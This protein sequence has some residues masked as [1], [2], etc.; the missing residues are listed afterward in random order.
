MSLT[1]KDNKRILLKIEFQ[2]L[3]ILLIKIFIQNTKLEYFFPTTV[4]Q[5][6]TQEVL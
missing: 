5:I 6:L 4:L 3:H 2:K 1:L